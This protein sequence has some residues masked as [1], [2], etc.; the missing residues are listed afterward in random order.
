MTQAALDFPM[1]EHDAQ[2]LSAWQAGI[3]IAGS[4][5]FGCQAPNPNAATHWHQLTP[6]LDAMRKAI[7]NRCQGD[8]VFIA[9]MASFFNAE[10]GQKLLNKAGA[11][12]FGNLLTLLDDRRRA[13]IADLFHNFRSWT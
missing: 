13:V 9:A 6:K 12:A 8:A 1:D 10:E 4:S 7:P 2:F 11:H 5:L 3:E